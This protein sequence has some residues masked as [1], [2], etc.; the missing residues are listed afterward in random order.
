MARGRKRKSGARTKSGQLSRAGKPRIKV[1]RGNDRAAKAWDIYKGNGSDAI[2]RAYERGL[3]GKGADAKTMLDTARSVSRI[4]WK[5]YN[6]GPTR[7]TLA[8]RTGGAAPE[9][10][11]QREARQEKWLNTM[12]NIAGP[13]GLERRKCFDAL[14]I[15]IHPDSGPDWLDRLLANKPTNSDQA[16]LK[17]ARDVLADCAGVEL[18][19]ARKRA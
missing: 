13:M 8:D 4:Y 3:L 11:D 7:C 2:G 16:R 15:D 6:N 14:V 12:L 18:Y 17:H 9:G 1:E 5:W 19:P 10:D